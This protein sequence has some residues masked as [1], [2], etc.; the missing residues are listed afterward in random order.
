MLSCAVNPVTGQHEL[1]LLSES[2]EI[3][4]GN[5]TNV[6]VTETYGIYDDPPLAAYIEHIGQRMASV[7]HRPSLP[8]E[9]QILDSAVVNAFAVPGGYVY[10]TR[11]VLSYLNSEAELAGVLGHEI[12][13][14]T[15]RHSAQQYSRAQLAQLGL[16]VG[17]LLSEDFQRYAGLAQSGVGMLFLRFS[18]DNERQA[19][20]LGVEYATKAGF[21]ASHMANFFETLER[22]HPSSDR[23]GLEGWFST[24]PNP[25]DRIRAVQREAEKWAGE[26]G[27]RD[28]KVSR[29]A[30][31]RHI[32]GLVFGENPR[33]GYVD[34][35]VFYH[36]AL[37]F[38]FPVPVDWKLN[39]RPAQVQMVSKRQDAVILFSVEPGYSPGDA[40]S[41]FIG[42][43]RARVIESNAADINQLPAECLICD[44]AAQQG[45]IR[46]M[47]CFI[48]HGQDVFVFHGFSSQPHFQRYRSFFHAT[49][50]GF[51]ALTDPKRINVK[52]DRLRVHTV[53]TAGTLEDTLRLLDVPDD[54][55]NEMA[56]LNGKY[57]HDMIP[58]D[59][60]VKVV[61]KGSC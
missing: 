45:T 54:K 23:S 22:L 9:F 16:G 7:S 19:D 51:R 59:F 10:L 32:D 49:M 4:L 6:Q 5:K 38:Q 46:V 48:Q 57:L 28:L 33:Q 42:K 27:V 31:L 52:P 58:A 30:Y 43:A 26:L 35:H 2:D 17:S 47:S 36:P 39:N 14:V 53:R 37:K 21:D 55:L 11:G 60:L 61:E 50:S 24:H 15:A 44:I 20:D 1:M 3:R 13:H 18:R 29:D 8:F 40:V 41:R 25:P 34:N 12:G 56:L